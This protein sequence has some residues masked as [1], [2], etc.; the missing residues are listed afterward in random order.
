MPA[1]QLPL[2]APQGQAALSR[3]PY[4]AG[5]GNLPGAAQE[6][7]RVATGW[8]GVPTAH[9]PEGQGSQQPAAH[10]AISLEGGQ[11]E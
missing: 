1:P 6:P 8:Q 5:H 3:P 2:G 9:S 11:S 7:G 10:G 4:L